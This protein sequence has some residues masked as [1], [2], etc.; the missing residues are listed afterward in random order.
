MTGCIVL[1]RL[2]C[3]LAVLIFIEEV[4]SLVDNIQM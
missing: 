2:D 4:L 1:V 3:M